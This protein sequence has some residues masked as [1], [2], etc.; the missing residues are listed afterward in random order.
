MGKSAL[1]TKAVPTLIF[2]LVVLNR[3]FVE[4]AKKDR[5]NCKSFSAVQKQQMKQI[6]KSEAVNLRTG[7]QQMFGKR[8]PPCINFFNF[9]SN[10]YLCFKIALFLY[11]FFLF[12]IAFFFFFFFFFWISN[13]CELHPQTP[14]ALGLHLLKKLFFF[15]KLMQILSLVPI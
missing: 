2:L 9:F 14:L 10:F 15:P 13:F 12:F 1:K 6:L 5:C 8:K 7:M 4:A 11:L 3:F